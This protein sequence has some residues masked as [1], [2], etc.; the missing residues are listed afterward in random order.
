MKI[1]KGYIR[2][3][4]FLILFLPFSANGQDGSNFSIGLNEETISKFNFHISSIHSSLTQ[5]NKK[6]NLRSNDLVSMES[7]VVKEIIE[8]FAFTLSACNRLVKKSNVIFERHTK[9]T[10]DYTKA[11]EALFK[12]EKEKKRCDQGD[13]PADPFG[14]YEWES[15]IFLNTMVERQN[16]KLHN[17]FRFNNYDNLV[18]YI[19]RIENH[20]PQLQAEETFMQEIKFRISKMLDTAYQ[21]YGRYYAEYSVRRL[22]KDVTGYWQFPENRTTVMVT[23]R[24]DDKMCYFDAKVS[25]NDGLVKFSRGDLIFFFKQPLKESESRLLKGEEWEWGKSKDRIYGKNGKKPRK[26]RV[27]L[28]FEKN[29]MF[30]AP[31]QKHNVHHILKKIAALDGGDFQAF[32]ME[33]K[34]SKT[35][36]SPEELKVGDDVWYQQES[37]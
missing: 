13:C 37:P 34:K 33:N 15:K 30:Y 7:Y 8:E 17:G 22:I 4:L 14:Q 6:F 23:A 24:R 31:N 11:K 18:S 26:Q 36:P 21:K 2:V 1:A 28:R 9:L 20:F 19:S 27:Y 16:I 3:I 35:I 29:Q 32:S 10:N 5:I 25:K 12:V